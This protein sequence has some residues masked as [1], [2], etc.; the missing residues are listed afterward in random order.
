MCNGKNTYTLCTCNNGAVFYS[1]HLYVQLLCLNCLFV[2]LSRLER[3]TIV[4][5]ILL[6]RP[7]NRHDLLHNDNE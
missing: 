7:L 4:L 5:R 2:L 6:L 1:E 3:V